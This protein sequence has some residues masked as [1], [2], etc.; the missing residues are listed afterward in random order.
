MRSSIAV[1]LISRRANR[2]VRGCV[3]RLAFGAFALAG[4]LATT[5]AALEA[6][7]APAPAGTSRKWELVIP[8]G[9]VIPVGAQRDAIQRG[10]M[11]ALQLSYVFDP[12]I[13]VTATVGWARSRDIADDHDRK[14]DLFTYDV[15]AE[16]RSRTWRP[17]SF[18]VSGF[19]G[20]G[21]GARS[22]NY[23]HIEADA[24]HNLAAYG[25]LGGEVGVGPVSV[26]V[27]ARDYVSGFKPLEGA[28]DTDARNDVALLFGLRFGTR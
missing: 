14:L 13:A 24:T 9:T 23:R 17:G 18:R 28:G 10:G 16:L 12:S 26:R 27:E 1:S 20:M 25:S 19:A 4:L 7:Q 11:S 22:Y 5:G 2:P 6:Q 3:A 8:S 21:A 15:G